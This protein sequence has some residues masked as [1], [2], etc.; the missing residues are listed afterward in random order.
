MVE[1]NL[2][3][4]VARLA[5]Q[6][7]RP[8]A[9]T[10]ADIYALLTEANIGLD[11]ETVT[12]E[13]PV[14]DG[15][16]R[17]I[18]VEIGQCVI[19]VKKNL[20]AADMPKAE[21]QLGGYVK[22][23]SEALGRYVGILT[24]GSEWRLYQ[25]RE[26]SLDLVSTHTLNK[27]NPD[28]EELL[29]WLESVMSTL[30]AIKPIPEE[31]EHRLGA[32]SPAHQLDA[33]ELHA[34]YAAN[35]DNKEVQL[36]RQLWAKLLR[37]A[38]GTEF[39]DSEELF[40]NHTLLVTTA[41]L[42]A[43]AVLGFD[44]GPTGSLTARQITSG[45]EFSNARI[46]GVVEADFFDW[47]TDTPTGESFVR[48][49]GR[50][51][52]RFDW[53]AVEHDVL[54]ILYESVITKD[55]RESLGE[56][57]TP[58]WLAER[59]VAEFIVA[60]LE[61]VVADPSCG[62]GTFL[63]HAIRRYLAAAI[64]AGV[65]IDDAV[66]QTTAHVVGLDVHPV[67]VT[68]ARVTYLLA[69]G[70]DNIKSPTRKELNIPVYLGDSVQWKQEADIFGSEVVRVSTDESDLFGQQGGMFTLDLSFPRSVLKDATQFDYL[71]SEMADKAMTTEPKDAGK[72]AAV[73]LKRRGIAPD[74]KDG[75][76]LR[77][78]FSNL[79][80]LRA[81]GRNH[82]WGYYVR[83]LIRPLWLAE[84][85]NRV[86]A[87]IGN[88]PWL[89][90]SK[91]TNTMQ[92]NYRALAKPRNLLT[93]G[94]GASARDLS[95]LFV[96]RAV[97]LYLRDGGSFAFVMPHGVIT[98]KPHTGFRSGNWST[99]Q[100]N[101]LTVK[102]ADSWD[103]SKVTTGFPM[104]SSVVHGNRALD[105]KKMPTKTLGWVGRLTRPDV[106]WSVA[107]EKITTTDSMV[108]VL[109]HG[110][111]IPESPYKARFRAGAILYPRSLMF[112]V[113]APAGP[114]G[115][116]AGRR[117]VTS[118]RNNLEKKPWK[119]C[120]SLKANVETSFIRPVYLGEQV[121]PFRTLEPR[122]AVLPMSDTAILKPDEIEIHDGLNAWWAE[123]ES[124]WERH[125]PKTET[126]PLSER[127]DYHAQL[128]AQLPVSPVR[129]VYTASGNTLAASIIRDAR[130][131]IEHKLYWM[132]AMVESEAHYLC[133]IL[134]SAPV[135]TQVQP[136]QAIGLFG[137][138][139]FDKNV[140]AVPF[141]TFD[142]DDSDHQHL[143]A[144]GKQAEKEAA[145]VDVSGVTTFQA[146]RMLIRGHLVETGTETAIVTAVTQLLL[147]VT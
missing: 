140:F 55:V 7:S 8:E 118:F 50:R 1:S 146:A 124:T 32:E 69:L 121:L 25:L 134:N 123:A 103:L 128:S 102:F 48:N 52:A 116:G 147:S 49:L 30:T 106:P 96:V 36:K 105:A 71:V 28:A 100:G 61:T 131:V 4:I 97:E 135:L 58:D 14:E 108:S 23:R 24:D 20:H 83:N 46:R 57:Y 3:K 127:M 74:S 64:E 99:D 44:V 145:T 80:T 37:A 5:A 31:I 89:R 72:A 139:D 92:A 133:A 51:V 40:I 107:K 26:T 54:K 75:G 119:D 90:Y 18:D 81:Q 130:A 79:C 63:F 35:A 111:E 27:Q 10:Q 29:I 78:T 86:D 65:Q 38:L 59:M 143:A 22:Q 19:E 122:N 109:D 95:T 125:R 94:L 82:I 117:A 142:P 9:T 76:V 67:A 33:A 144:L 112:V 17:R 42:I 43:H 68:L 93:G 41:E 11:G 126:K 60:P 85:E 129:V 138:R 15:T 47:V 77:E 34:I 70:R 115:A 104:T 136:L 98:R 45:S 87:L 132:P 101:H 39:V 21:Q 88:P 53:G 16:K 137:G 12:M 113:D 114:F 62:S 73:I 6:T 13:S 110:V 141:P 91:M 56:Y 66:Q 84:P 2:N 120:D